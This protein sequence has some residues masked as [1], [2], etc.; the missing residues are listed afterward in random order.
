[1]KSTDAA[2]AE[3]S[4]SGVFARLFLSQRGE[5]IKAALAMVFGAVF[6]GASVMGN[7]TPFGISLAAALNGKYSLFALLGAAFGYFA[8]G[9]SAESIGYI[10]QLFIVASVKWAFSDFFKEHS[11]IRLPVLSGVVHLVVG[12]ALLFT[13]E[14]T[15]YDALL[16][17]SQSLICAGAVYFICRFLSVVSAGGSMQNAENVVALSVCSAISL[18]SLS[19]IVLGFISLGN[20]IAALS[21]IT[22]AYSLGTLSGACAGLAVGTALSL[23]VGDGGFLVISLG[24][25]GMLSGLF[26]SYSKTACTVTFVL[27]SVLSVLISNSAEQQLYFMYEAI[28]ASIIFFFIPDRTLKFLSYYFPGTSAGEYYPNKYLSSRLEFVSKNLSETSH[29]LC[30]LSNKLAEK[31]SDNSDRVFSQA[32]DRVCRRC[33][34]KLRC[35]DTSYTDTMDSFNHMLPSLRRHGRIEPEHIP[36]LLRHR[37]TKLTQLVSEIN[38]AY[39]KNCSDRQIAQRAKQMKEIITEQFDGVSKLLSEMSQEISLTMCDRETESKVLSRLSQ[40]GIAVCEVSCIADKFGRKTVE[41]Y[42]T[43]SDADEIENEELEYSISEICKT[44]ML[45][46]GRVETGELARLSFSQVPPYSVEIGSFQK[47][48]EGESVCGDSFCSLM[49]DNGFFAVVLSDGMGHGKTAALD[50]K[51]T[52]SLVSRFLSLGFKTEN[53]VSLVNSALMLKSEQETLSTLDTAVFDLYSASVVIKKAGAAPSFLR[54][55]KRV[56]KIEMG[57]LPLGILNSPKLQS[58]ELRLSRADTLV[59]CSDGMALGDREVESI[60]RK[61]IDKS[62]KQIAELMGKKASECKERAAEDD[63]TVIVMSLK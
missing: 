4:K 48:A 33:A 51:M 38:G 27:C 11:L 16:L 22:V 53:C 13:Y 60:L 62:P 3:N 52:V 39:H 18:I 58:A 63:I 25:G 6:S 44:P 29:S 36:D 8:Q 24:L 50:S 37:C 41:F 26:S 47:K 5:I 32:A 1:M 15:V 31:Y 9:I 12:A 35:W 10:A 55:G 49:L 40:N 57:S 17:I 19:Q 45:M 28:V 42:C 59:L 20:V 30:E 56:S 7:L 46:S 2:V 43:P 23:S 61:N 54:R 21:V 34:M 14:A